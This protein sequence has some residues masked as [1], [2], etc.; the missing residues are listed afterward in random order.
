MPL[1]EVSDR[2]SVSEAPDPLFVIVVL[3]EEM[4]PMLLRFLDVSTIVVVPIAMLL[5]WNWTCCVPSP[6]RSLMRRVSAPP[7]AVPVMKSQRPL[8]VRF[9]SLGAELL[10]V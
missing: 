9:V 10:F 5:L 8:G 1:V 2:V 3:P 6:P 7:D 4:V